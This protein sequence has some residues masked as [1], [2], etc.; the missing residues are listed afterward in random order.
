MKVDLPAFGMPKQAHVGQHLQLQAQFAPFAFLALGLLARCAVG[1]GLEVDIA[2]AAL[3]ALGQQFDLAVF[4]QV[5]DDL[6]VVV[7]DDQGA[8]RHAHVDVFRALAIAVRAA[9]RFA[10]FALVHFG[11]AEVDQGVD[12]A[13]GDRPDGA[14]LAAVAA[15]R[16]AEGAELLAAERGAAIPAVAG[17]DFDFC[18]VDKLHNFVPP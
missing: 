6:A 8:D 17:D 3:A 1:R 13:V 9:A 5:G 4:G 10:V 16:T 18:F 15:V 11:V 7:I 2:P 14:A 12:V